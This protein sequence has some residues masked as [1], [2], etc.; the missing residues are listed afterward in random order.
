MCNELLVLLVSFFNAKVKGA[1]GPRGPHGPRGLHGPPGPRGKQ[2]TAG[3]RGRTGRRGDKGPT[4]ASEAAATG[5]SNRADSVELLSVVE[6]QIEDIYRELDVQMKRIAQLQQQV[7]DL[8]VKL[9][10]QNA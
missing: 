3:S 6:S 5:Q 7:D 1:H 2:G 8:R 10:E 9:R 4:G